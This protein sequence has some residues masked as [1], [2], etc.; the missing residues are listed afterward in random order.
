LQGPVVVLVLVV[1]P[2]H[3]I[4]EAGVV[5]VAAVRIDYPP[6]LGW[7]ATCHLGR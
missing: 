6:A 5:I 4:R 3:D 7:G 2:V 1:V